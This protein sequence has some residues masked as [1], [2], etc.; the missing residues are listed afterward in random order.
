MIERGTNNSGF[1][2]TATYDGLNRRIQ[3]VT[4]LVSNGVAAT[5]PKT[6]SSYFDPQVEFLELGVQS[7]A[8]T[9]WILYGPDLNGQYGGLNGAGGLEGVSQYL[10]AFNLTISDARGNVLAE[11]TN[12]AVSWNPSRPTGYGAVPGYRPAPFG[13]GA[14]M[15]QSS[16]WRGREV[17]ITGYAQLGLRPFDP[18]S[19]RWLSFDPLGS[20]SL[21]PDGF[22]FCGGDSVNYF[23]PDGRMGKQALQYAYNGGAAGQA[24]R[25]AGSIFEYLGS[26]NTPGTG[27]S[28]TTFF[29]W[30][31]NNDAT[32]LNYAASAITPSSYVNGYNS[33]QSRAE[34][35]MVGEYLRGSGGTWAA[36][37]GL[38]SIVGDTVGYNGIY[39]GGFGVDRQSGTMLGGADRWSRGL[40]GGSQMILTGVG[41]K[42]AYNPDATF[43]RSSSTSPVIGGRSLPSK[44]TLDQLY[45]RKSPWRQGVRQQVY[46]GAPKD[47]GKVFDPYTGIE[48]KYNDPWEYGHEPQYKFSDWQKR[49][50]VENWSR[51]DWNNFLNDPATYRPETRFTNGGHHA[52]DT[53]P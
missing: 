41:L 4:L 22:T 7:G 32:L 46:E 31:L 36:A 38:S 40:M 48:I 16:A 17:D 26:L 25:N 3:T 33:L 14:D 47:N 2:W 44:A 37:Q 8:Q 13:S 24:L 30:G 28:D 42:T 34:N 35:V 5:A 6:I 12:G 21:D 18:V 50:W 52:E 10:N 19:G 29:R 43:L 53:H 51:E 39:E 20:T 23:D 45:P 27:L 49:A 9:A 1:N 11:M 15:A